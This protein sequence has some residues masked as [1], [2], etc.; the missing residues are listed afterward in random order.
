MLSPFPGSPPE[1]LYPI[2]HDHCF[3]EGAPPP[4]YP[5][6]PQSPSIHLCWVIEPP[7]DQKASLPLMPD[8]AILYYICSWSH[9][10]LH[11]YS[12][13]GGLVSGSSGGSGWLV[14]LFFLWGRKPLNL[15]QF[16]P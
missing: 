4:T 16:S 7:P 12:L 10:S 9:R 14:L 13:F 5:L 15:L 11:M 8:K 1:F 3:Y 6:P 2:P